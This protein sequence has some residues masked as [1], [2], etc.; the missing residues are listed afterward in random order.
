MARKPVTNKP[1]TA[2]A[3][4][5]RAARSDKG[6]ARGSRIKRKATPA[7]VLDK[8]HLIDVIQA[9]TGSTKKAAKDTLAAILNTITVSLK[10]NKKVQLFG[11]GSFRVVRLRARKARNP[12]TGEAIRAKASNTVRF[13]AGT[14]LKGG[15]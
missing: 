12:G 6:S 9:G 2:K 11:F 1:R 14:K 15:I 10:R 8:D 3:P 5:K 13:K 7:G 4:S